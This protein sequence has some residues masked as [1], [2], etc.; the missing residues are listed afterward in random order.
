MDVGDENVGQ[1]LTQYLAKN[2]CRIPVIGQISIN[3]SFEL[4]SI[5]A[6]AWGC[7]FLFIDNVQSPTMLSGWGDANTSNQNW[8]VTPG[9]LTETSQ[10][11]EVVPSLPIW[12]K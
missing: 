1:L 2:G 10:L 8:G 4:L 5:P 3:G 6:G 12:I 7:G 9:D 11:P